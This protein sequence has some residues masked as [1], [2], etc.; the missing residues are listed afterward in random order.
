MRLREHQALRSKSVMVTRKVNTLE[1][2]L[3]KVKGEVNRADALTKYTDLVAI[4]NHVKWTMQANTVGRH[5]LM[6]K[7]SEEN[8]VIDGSEILPND[9]E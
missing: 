5:E 4:G 1:I 9:P 7:M 2:E 3:E 8:V 6:P